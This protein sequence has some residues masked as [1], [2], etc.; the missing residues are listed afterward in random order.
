MIFVTMSSNHH[1]DSWCT[2][3]VSNIAHDSFNYVRHCHTRR[4]LN[5]TTVK[6]NAPLVL[7]VRQQDQKSIAKTDVV[8]PDAHLT[9]VR[10]LRLACSRWHYSPN[11]FLF[12]RHFLA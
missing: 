10:R 2:V 3:V 12:R 1:V 7:S 11:S 6:Q 8:H 4:S 5:R 9:T